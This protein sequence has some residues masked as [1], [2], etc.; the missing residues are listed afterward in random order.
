MRLRFARMSV[1]GTLSALVL[2]TPAGATCLTSMPTF[3]ESVSA[4]GFQ[5]QYCD[6]TPIIL[7]QFGAGLSGTADA[8]AIAFPASLGAK[9]QAVYI[10]PTP[11]AQISG[12]SASAR[13]EDAFSYFFGGVPSGRAILSLTFNLAGTSTVTGDALAN[14][15]SVNAVF[16]AQETLLGSLDEA[17]LTGPGIAVL[18]VE[19]L[20]GARSGVLFNADLEVSAVAQSPGGAIVDYSDTLAL[21]KIRL[22]DLGGN[23]LQDNVSLTDPAGVVF[24]GRAVDAVPVPSGIVLF[25]SGVLTLSVAASTSSRIRRRRQQPPFRRWSIHCGCTQGG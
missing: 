21:S 15:T 8:S 22:L 20:L 16:T 1:I 12:A 9:A 3:L 17:V 5:Q 2:T 6:T 23:L 11:S 25:A 14:R 24:P 4:N 10:L 13:V 19:V 18:R 7:T